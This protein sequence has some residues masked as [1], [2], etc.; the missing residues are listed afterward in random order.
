M[1]D[2]SSSWE[3]SSEDEAPEP[4]KEKTQPAKKPAAKKKELKMR[5]EDADSWE[6]D[7]S[8]E[9]P[10]PVAKVTEKKAPQKDEWDDDSDDEVD[11]DQQPKAKSTKKNKVFRDKLRAKEARNR[12]KKPTNDFDDDESSEEEVEGGD[13]SERNLQNKKGNAM[14]FG[15]DKGVKKRAIRR[16]VK[17][18]PETLKELY[19]INTK[20]RLEAGKDLKK[21]SD[22]ISNYILDLSLGGLDQTGAPV[23]AAISPNQAKN[24]VCAIISKCCESLDFTQL[25]D[26]RR[27]VDS[28]MTK[29]KNDE[30]NARKAKRRGQQGKKKK[31]RKIFV[32]KNEDPVYVDGSY[33]D[34][35]FDAFY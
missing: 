26:I 18:V 17:E 22:S 6:E 29:F 5:N 34:T 16:R 27:Q 28:Q 10:E 13:I 7:E 19:P 20:S 1:A 2:D 23:K 33:N 12:L 15:D 4:V 25:A 11:P 31:A 8:D 21:F 24:F 35:D 14:L 3:D 30:L 32:E 9:E